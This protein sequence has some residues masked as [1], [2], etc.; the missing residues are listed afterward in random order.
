MLLLTGIKT[1]FVYLFSSSP[2]CVSILLEMSC[3]RYNISSDYQE[4]YKIVSCYCIWYGLKEHIMIPLSSLIKKE[5]THTRIHKLLFSGKHG[6]S[7]PDQN[8]RCIHFITKWWKWFVFVLICGTDVLLKTRSGCLCPIF[9]LSAFCTAQG[10]ENLLMQPLQ[11]HWA[12]WCKYLMEILE[13]QPQTRK[14]E[15]T[16]KVWVPN[17]FCHSL[18]QFG[19]GSGGRCTEI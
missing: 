6:L 1:P 12:V 8:S 5:K 14:R 11:R 3:N 15:L 7:S 4:I 19:Q 18:L 2:C 13:L 9:R 10:G 17:G 16:W